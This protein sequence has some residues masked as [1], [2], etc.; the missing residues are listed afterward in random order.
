MHGH[1]NPYA[2]PAAVATEGIRLPLPKTGIAAMIGLS[3]M[4][5]G[6]YYPYWMFTRGQAINAWAQRELVNT[7]AI[8]GLGILT[9]AFPASVLVRAFF[10]QLP[11]YHPE[12]M[13]VVDVLQGVDGLTGLGNLVATFHIRGALHRL[14]RTHQLHRPILGPLTTLLFGILYFQYRLNRGLL[15]PVY[16]LAKAPPRKR[17]KRDEPERT[18]KRR[19]RRREVGA[20][21]G[22]GG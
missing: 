21:S 6:L 10:M 1:D 3:I 19:R 11:G 14:L 2:A 9:A 12:L 5:V 18:K 4:T 13:D 17:K 20:P 8:V 7:R 22:D 15:D 16:D